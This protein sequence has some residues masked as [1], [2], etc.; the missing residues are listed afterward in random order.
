MKSYIIQGIA[1]LASIMST[2]L[3]SLQ[4][5]PTVHAQSG[6]APTPIRGEPMTGK[7]D[8]SRPQAYL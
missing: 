6:A 7:H 1:S 5:A 8:E 2:G 4:R 3:L